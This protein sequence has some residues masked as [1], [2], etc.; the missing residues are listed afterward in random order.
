M[1]E[2]L[3][4]DKKA[5]QATSSSPATAQSTP[6]SDRKHIL[7][8]PQ[9]FVSR[10]DGSLTPLVAVDEL[11]SSIHI[12][13]VPPV[14]SQAETINMTSLG[15]KERTQIKYIVETIDSSASGNSGNQV[16]ARS[17]PRLSESSNQTLELPVVEKMPDVGV[18]NVEEWRHAVKGVD[19]TQVS[20]KH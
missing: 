13:G 16:S 10:N 4:M 7:P 6:I 2:N 17:D 3:A 12:I 15:V 9:Y 5:E 11:P 20:C 18:Q 8:R 19:E 14:I 1:S